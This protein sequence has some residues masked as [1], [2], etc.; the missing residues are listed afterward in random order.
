MFSSHD[1]FVVLKYDGWEV[2]GKTRKTMNVIFQV[3]EVLS[4]LELTLTKL[5]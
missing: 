2:R 3:K 4:Y 5:F 1:S